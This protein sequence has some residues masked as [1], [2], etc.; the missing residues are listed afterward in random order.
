MRWDMYV[1]NEKKKIQKAGNINYT[2]A[3]AESHF[4][5]VLS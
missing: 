4:K 5:E 3:S 2:E 1:E